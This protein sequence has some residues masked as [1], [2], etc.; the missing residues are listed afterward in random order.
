MQ[1]DLTHFYNH[2]IFYNSKFK[3]DTVPNNSEEYGVAGIMLIDKI[4]PTFQLYQQIYMY[5]KNIDTG[6]D[7]ILCDGQIISLNH[8]SCSQICIIGFCEYGT[9]SEY[10]QIIDMNAQLH[11]VEF[12]LKTFHTNSNQG[13]DNSPK[14]KKCLLIDKILGN[15]DQKHNIFLW[16]IPWNPEIQIDK[17]I[18]PINSSLHIISIII[19]K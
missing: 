7:N 16:N 11:E 4:P 17:I 3:K 12:V 5:P 18:L 15:D 6:F 14:N 13:I 1:I 9:V 2:C 10:L 8:V 19:D